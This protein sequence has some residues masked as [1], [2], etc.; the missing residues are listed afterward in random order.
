MSED[1]QALEAEQ[2]MEAEAGDVPGGVPEDEDTDDP[3]HWVWR[4]DRL[5]RDEVGSWGQ[6]RTNRLRGVWYP[7]M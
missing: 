1:N 2:A 4:R 6:S 7:S 3:G 5:I